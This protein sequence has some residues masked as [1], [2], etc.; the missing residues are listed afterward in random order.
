MRRVLLAFLIILMPACA[1]DRWLTVEE[2]ADL[3]ARCEP[4]GGCTAIPT[5]IWLKIEMLLKHLA[6]T[7][8]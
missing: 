1:S 7:A 2:D 3:R 5:P 8:I 4:H 6:G